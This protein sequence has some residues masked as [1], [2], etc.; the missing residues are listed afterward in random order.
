MPRK[1]YKQSEG[2]KRKRLVSFMVRR[3]RLRTPPVVVFCKCGCGQRVKTHGREWAVGHNPEFRRKHSELLKKKYK[4][5]GNP[6]FG[7]HHSRKTKKKLSRKLKG[8]V[9][10]FLG[11]HHSCE[12]RRLLSV[13]VMRRFK[14]GW[15]PWHRKLFRRGCIKIW[16]RSSWE[17]AFAKWCHMKGL[18]WNYE[19][20][21]FLLSVGG[22]LPDF[23]VKEWNSYVEIKGARI[24]K[25]LRKLKAFVRETENSLITYFQEDLETI[26]VLKCAR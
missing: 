6:F 24:E 25:A 4:S 20:K 1:G 9:S 5:E 8:R 15:V 21:S 18:H 11:K 16:M 14:E 23:F 13:S 22:Y 10:T 17:V 19:K 26:G 2:H 7:K 12:S 3:E